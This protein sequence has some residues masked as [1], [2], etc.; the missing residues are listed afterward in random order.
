ME[1]VTKCHQVQ[2]CWVCGAEGAGMMVHPIPRGQVAALNSHGG[3]ACAQEAKLSLC[4]HDRCP[5]QAPCPIHC[6]TQCTNLSTHGL[7]WSL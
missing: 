4:P 3:S 5:G 2:S 1:G 6:F 7:S